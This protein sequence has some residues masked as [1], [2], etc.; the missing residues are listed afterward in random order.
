M[1]PGIHPKYEIIKVT[2]ACGNVF[3]TRSTKGSETLTV[4]I[5]SACHPFYTGKQKLMDAAGRI[6]RFRRRYAGNKP[7]A[8]KE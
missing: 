1:K 2:C 3:E 5:C 8:A 4:D 7:A 6:E